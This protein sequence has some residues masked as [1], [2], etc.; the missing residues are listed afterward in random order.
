MIGHLVMFK[1]RTSFSGENRRA[2]LEMVREMV[3]GSPSIRRCSVGRRVRHG[4]PGYEQ[5]MREDYEYTLLL[6]FDDLEGL[7]TYLTGEAHHAAGEL[8]T[9]AASASLAYDYEMMPV[10]EAHALLQ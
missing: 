6:E 3:R 8:F 10:D 7:K 4:L 9:S 2:I 5:A 1:P